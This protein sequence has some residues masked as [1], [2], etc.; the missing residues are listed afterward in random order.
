MVSIYS[1]WGIKF[2]PRPDARS[3]RA[4]TKFFEGGATRRRE[5][6]RQ[7]GR[8]N[9]S[10]GT[11]G[12]VDRVEQM[13]QPDQRNKLTN[14]AKRNN[15][16]KQTRE[17]KGRTALRGQKGQTTTR[18]SVGGKN[19]A[20]EQENNETNQQQTTGLG[21]GLQSRAPVAKATFLEAQCGDHNHCHNQSGQCH[22]NVPNCHKVTVRHD[23]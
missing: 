14:G 15:L 12:N 13:G 10:M 6:P 9:E 2:I 1:Q 4:P 20:T 8:K 22:L 16:N 5:Q 19:G 7:E 18:Q 11:R 21:A 3:P 17:T 23:R